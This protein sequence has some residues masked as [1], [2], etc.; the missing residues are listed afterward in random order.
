MVLYIP[1]I[2]LCL[3]HLNLHPVWLSVFKLYVVT[4][5]NIKE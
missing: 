1:T 2:R 3:C 5:K 4:M